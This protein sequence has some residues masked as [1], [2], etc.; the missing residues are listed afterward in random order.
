MFIDYV[1][2]FFTGLF[3]FVVI[4]IPAI[5]IHEFGHL[6]MA[7]LCG[8]RIPEYGIGMPFS[9]RL[10][11]FKK[12]GTVWSFYPILLG[13]FVRI[14]GDN[15]ALDNAQE[16]RLADP[17][18]SR[19]DYID[20]RLSEILGVRE[21]QFFLEKNGLDYSKDWAL[22]EN[23][24]FINDKLVDS[25]KE[26]VPAFESKTKQLKTLIDWEYYKEIEAKDTFFH[27]NWLQQTI[28]II[29]G[30]TFNFITA[31]I[32]YWILFSFFVVPNTPTTVSLEDFNNY[33]KY[34][35][36]KSKSDYI[37][38]TVAD[39]GLAYN[40]GIRTGDKIY[41]FANQKLSDLKNL[42][43]FRNLLKQNKDKTIDVVY[44]PK[45]SAEKITKQ[46]QLVETDGKLLFGVGA[47]GVDAA[48]DKVNASAMSMN[49]IG[50]FVGMNFSAMGD[51]VK[52]LN[53]AQK[54]KTALDQVGGP[55]Y[56]SATF[57]KISKN[58][59]FEVYLQI[60]AA[61]SIGLAVFNLLPIPALDGGRWVI[62]TITKL[63]GRRNRR[64]EG[65]VITITFLFMLGLG[66]VIA[67]WDIFRIFKN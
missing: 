40:A 23:S 10:F 11:W 35:E 37:V 14:F 34:S 3:W 29:G 20:A 58:I 50:T 1:T 59:N 15:D 38:T 47:F 13:G 49:Q 41:T 46:I 45:D 44:Q 21:L 48:F 64:I 57:S 32:C 42:D 18:K 43:E 36:I 28:I 4:F 16:H 53:P 63:F 62:I 56:A 39:K 22:Y 5:A 17:Q 8:V 2:G 30:V 26:L 6:L 12:F 65:A 61:I 24:K 67:G 54:D 25:E 27:K 19:E 33:S 9:K 31:F 55:I 7:K 52:A 66:V 60:L 51:A